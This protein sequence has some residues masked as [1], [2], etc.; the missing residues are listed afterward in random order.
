MNSGSGVP[1]ARGA[2][3]HLPG[4][5]KPGEPEGAREGLTLT[6]TSFL[7]EEAGEG[8]E[9]TDTRGAA[10]IVAVTLWRCAHVP[11]LPTGMADGAR[12]AHRISLGGF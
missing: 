5:R 9:A 6:G 11:V 3:F 4:Q 10:C 2:S 1:A 8:H 7:P 12:D